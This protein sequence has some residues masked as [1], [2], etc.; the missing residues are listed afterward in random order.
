MPAEQHRHLDRR[1][2]RRRFGQHEHRLVALAEAAGAA[3]AGLRIAVG[4]QRG[5]DGVFAEVVLGVA[6]R[7]RSDAGR[8]AVH[9]HLELAEEEV[10]L[11]PLV[12][13]QAGAVRRQAV[14][15]QGLEPDG[16]HR[17]GR[18]LQ[19]QVVAVALGGVAGT[20][21]G[22]VRLHGEQRQVRAGLL[23]PQQLPGNGQ[24]PLLLQPAGKSGVDTAA[25]LGGRPLGGQL[26]QQPGR[27]LEPGLVLG[28]KLRIRQVQIG[29]VGVVEEGHQP[30]VFG[31]GDRIELV[32]VALAAL[33][34]QPQPSGAGGG[35]A[36]GHGVEPEFQR[37]DAAL[38]VEHR[39]AVE[40][41]GDLLVEG[42]AG[43]QVAG[44][45]LDREPVERHVG[46]EG[47]DHP[48]AV[49]PDAALAVLLV[50]VGVR[51]AGQIEPAPGPAFAVVRRFEQPVDVAFDHR[52]RPGTG[53]TVV[54]HECLQFGHG[55]RQACQ[56]K[57]QPAGQ[58]VRFGRRRLFQARGRQFLEDKRVDRI[59]HAPGGGPGHRR[60]HRL[61]K[62]P[63]RGILRAFLHPA[64][65]DRLLS[66]G[67]RLFRRRWRHEFI[68]VRMEDAGDE[69]A[70]GGLA[71]H[72]GA[73]ARL[74]RLQRLFT[75]VQAQPALAA[76]LV[77]T[78]AV[79]AVVGQDGPDVALK[80]QRGGG[81]RR[82]KR[83]ENGGG[84]SAHGGS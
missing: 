44:E 12:A 15:R 51:V 83:Q 84:R 24:A 46:V 25:G 37:I 47:A 68:R 9:A 4:G 53:R 2:G 43:Q 31:V 50:A 55:G 49:R 81:K 36:V 21:H 70:G 77:R 64:L 7:G 39:V 28:G 34:G 69:F 27:L 19:A 67:D 72:K 26:A 65:E 35:H 45:L 48:V 58:G 82:G 10:A 6:F 18:R 33:Q 73:R 41:R 66:L 76:L 38:L 8:P 11:R 71:G 23:R 61:G 42:G 17:L 3:P 63:V 75:D 80:I 29:L 74:R 40:T 57:R 54:A 30:V 13:A 59:V 60:R 32:G 5:A 78:V 22:A 14:V 20:E 62:G 1:S 16:A 56:V 79:V 52:R